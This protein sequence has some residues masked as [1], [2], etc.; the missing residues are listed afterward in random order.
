MDQT[1]KEMS[2]PSHTTMTSA[3]FGET[4]SRLNTMTNYMFGQQSDSIVKGVKE[5]QNKFTRYF[6]KPVKLS[7]VARA[8][9]YV[10]DVKLGAYF[11]EHKSNPKS[12]LVDGRQYLQI[13]SSSQVFP[14][15]QVGEK[16]KY[17]EALVLG[18]Y[19][20][21]SGSLQEDARIRAQEFEQF[22]QLP[23]GRMVH[24]LDSWTESVEEFVVEDFCPRYVDDYMETNYVK[25]AGTAVA[26]ALPLFLIYMRRACPLEL[27]HLKHSSSIQTI[28]LENTR[29]D[30]CV[31]AALYEWT[32]KG[33]EMKEP[34][35]KQ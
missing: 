12:N 8:R 5:W 33:E 35:N 16:S 27:P 25:V 30:H 34:T 20:H 23:N 6:D 28:S 19:E 9:R 32:Q 7:V 3:M 29:E 14:V 10:M 21:R 26:C 18:P 15:P 4:L 11:Y 1:E 13:S 2:T 22:P 31:P 17:Y 24:E